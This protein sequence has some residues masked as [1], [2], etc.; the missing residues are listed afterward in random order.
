MVSNEAYRP[1]DLSAYWT[2]GVE[3]LRDGLE[4]R[5]GRQVFQGIPFEIGQAD[6]SFIGFASGSS[7]REPVNVRVDAVAHCVVVAHRLLDSRLRDGTPVGLKVAEYVFRL[8]DGSRHSVP[9][10]ERFE[11]VDQSG[12]GQLPY[13]ALPDEHDHVQDRWSGG[14]GQAGFRQ[15]EVV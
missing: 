2:V 14:W 1:V 4:P 10:R 9:I 3:V 5:V 13:L 7:T 6:R 11:I 15:T 12:F 8:A